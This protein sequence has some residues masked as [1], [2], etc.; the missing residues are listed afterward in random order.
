MAAAF[1]SIG[2]WAVGLSFPV[3]RLAQQEA[4][5]LDS[6]YAGCDSSSR[7]GGA[8]AEAGSHKSAA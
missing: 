7:S 1:S 3:C 4:A 8:G 6:V 2:E 5:D